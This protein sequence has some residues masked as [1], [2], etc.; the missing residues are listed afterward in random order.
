[1]RVNKALGALNIIL[2]CRSHFHSTTLQCLY[3][4]KMNTNILYI[5]INRWM[6]SIFAVG[7]LLQHADFGFF[8]QPSFAVFSV[9][10]SVLLFDC[11]NNSNSKCEMTFI[12]IHTIKYV[13]DVVQSLFF[14]I[15]YIN[16]NKLS[17]LS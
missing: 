11:H 16:T 5:I 7:F 17:P 6:S 9:L 14:F 3:Y 1:M 2:F 10:P 15:R 8:Q 4:R 12:Y 13:V